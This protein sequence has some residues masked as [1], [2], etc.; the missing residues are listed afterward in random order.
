MPVLR[1]NVRTIVANWGIKAF[2]PCLHDGNG[3]SG[4]IFEGDCRTVD[5]LGA[6]YSPKFESCCFWGIG[7]IIRLVALRIRIPSCWYSG[8]HVRIIELFSQASYRHASSLSWA[9]ASASLA[10]SLL[11]ATSRQTLIASSSSRYQEENDKIN[12]MHPAYYQQGIFRA[13]RKTPKGRPY[14]PLSRS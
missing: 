11:Q 9:I 12:K 7:L 4:A 3:I 1:S 6:L 13:C 10:S 8:W 14:V 5:Y 2:P